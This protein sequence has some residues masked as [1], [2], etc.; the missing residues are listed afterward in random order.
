MAIQPH[1]SFL[2]L[3]PNVPVRVKAKAARMETREITDPKTRQV[4]PLDM[5][6]LDITEVN[7]VPEQ[8]V[9]S[10][11]SFKAQQAL[12]PLV[13]SSELFRKV[14]E[15]TRRPRGYATEYELRL[16]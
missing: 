7:G 14:L 1:P 11:T 9:L 6:V 13:N 2:V 12:A 4:K 10:F 16:L 5:L 15:V 8:T 3:E